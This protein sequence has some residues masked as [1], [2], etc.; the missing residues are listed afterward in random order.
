MNKRELILNCLNQRFPPNFSPMTHIA[1]LNCVIEPL[2]APPKYANVRKT[3]NAVK[4][5]GLLGN[6]VANF[7]ALQPTR[8]LALGLASIALIG[9]YCN[10]VSLAEDNNGLWIDIPFPVPSAENSKVF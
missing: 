4:I 8:R 6:R 2:A 10:G 3:R 7:E 1:S 9:G 5:V